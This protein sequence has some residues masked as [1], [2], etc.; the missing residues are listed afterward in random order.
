MDEVMDNQKVVE[1]VPDLVAL[2][3][4][5]WADKL[6]VLEA[7]KMVAWKAYWQVYERV[8]QLEAFSAAVM[9]A[10]KAAIAAV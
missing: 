4:C 6:D 1:L 8:V 10:M 7:V 3:E 2:M 5:E 9:V